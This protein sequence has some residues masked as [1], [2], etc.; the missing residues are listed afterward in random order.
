MLDFEI[1]NSIEI[2]KDHGHFKHQ[3]K[4]ILHYDMAKSYWV[5][6][7]EC[8]SLNKMAPIGLLGVG[9]LGSLPLLE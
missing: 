7:V 5:Q 1:S 2:E 4:Y 3:S 8:G 9:L 6:E